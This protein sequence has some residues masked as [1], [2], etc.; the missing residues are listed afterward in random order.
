MADTS[1]DSAPD[2]AVL[3]VDGTLVDSTY[4]HAVAWFRAFAAL[5]EPQPLWRLHRLIGLGG[6]RLVAAAAGDD[7]EARLGD[8][9]RSRWDEEYTAIEDEVRPMAGA[10]DLLAELR[11]RGWKVALGSSSLPGHTAH[12]VELLGGRDAVDAVTS[13]ADAE[14]SKPAPD[15]WA[16]ALE[17][18]GGRSGIGLGDS[19]FDVESAGNLG[20]PC[21]AVRS[22][23]FGVAE[24]EDAGAVL[25]VDDVAEL[26]ARIDETPFARPGQG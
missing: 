9:L 12:G 18:A 20:W 14:S 19:T 24:L 16:A 10:R 6:D 3:D 13:S 7:V 26:L 15:I 8:D 22:G 11:R 25:V 17:A 21:I 23:G 4:H 5:S 1:A 2:T